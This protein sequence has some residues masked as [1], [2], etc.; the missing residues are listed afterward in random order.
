ML[1]LMLD[2]EFIKHFAE[3]LHVQ[4]SKKKKMMHQKRCSPRMA[5]KLQ[6]WQYLADERSSPRSGVS[7]NLHTEPPV[8][9]DP[10][11]SQVILMT[12]SS[13]SKEK[14]NSQLGTKF[15]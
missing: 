10:T 7:Q 9:L 4:A 5:L 15:Q 14:S 11:S 1:D 2:L 6:S 12:A 8:S 3:S 13:I